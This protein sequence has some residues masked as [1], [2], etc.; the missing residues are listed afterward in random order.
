[1]YV[2][3]INIRNYF[4]EQNKGYS[5]SPLEN[6]SRG[7]HSQCGV[8]ERVNHIPSCCCVLIANLGYSKGLVV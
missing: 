8:R 4:P 3:H 2:T 1:M 5:V 6:S 7:L